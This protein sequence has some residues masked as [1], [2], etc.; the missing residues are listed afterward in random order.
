MHAGH[1]GTDRSLLTGHDAI[2]LRQIASDLLHALLHKHNNIWTAFFEPV[3]VTGGSE[4][5]TLIEFHLS[6]T[7]GS[8]WREPGSPAW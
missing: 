5:I 7:S 8:R 6:V 3:V 2:L 4:S 1:I